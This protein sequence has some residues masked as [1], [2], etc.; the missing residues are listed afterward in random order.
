[1]R[2]RIANAV[3]QL[4]L[5]SAGAEMKSL[6]RKS[7]KQEY[8]WCGDK[9]YWGRTAP[10]LFPIVGRV[11]EDHYTYDGMEYELH[12]HGFARDMEFELL[13]SEPEEIWFYLK[14]NEE[15]KKKYPFDFI[16]QVGYRLEKS[17]V[18]VMWKVIN[19]DQKRLYFSIG[20]HPAFVCPLKENEKQ[21]DYKIQI[22]AKSSSLTRTN[23]LDGYAC[24]KLE[25][26]LLVDGCLEITNG[27][28]DRDA[29]IFEND[30]ANKV[31]LMTPGGQTYLSVSFDAPVFGIWSPVGKSAPFICIEPWYGRCD[32]A[33]FHGS[34]EEREWGN[35]LAPG[36]EFTAEYKIEI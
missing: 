21:T 27:I 11:V 24:H 20:G 1:M 4:T 3:I 26:I 10:V 19:K 35:E 36:A 14:A 7:D 2:Y 25:T 18:T 34:L 29:L 5:D 16:L 17:S 31:S 30:Q 15:T 28:F 9:K 33:D 23:F 6:M 22:D 32:K 12:Q 13:S 8:L